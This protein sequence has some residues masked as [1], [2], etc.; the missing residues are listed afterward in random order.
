MQGGPAES[1]NSSFLSARKKRTKESTHPTK[2]S[3]RGEDA[4]CFG[5]RPAYTK[6]LVSLAKPVP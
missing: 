2:A 3:P 6:D 1:A 4:I 5:Q